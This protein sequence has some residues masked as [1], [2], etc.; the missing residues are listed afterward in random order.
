MKFW[1]SSAILPLCLKE[2]QTMVIK[3]ILQAEEGMVVWWATSVECCSAFAR[4]R[5]EKVITDLDEEKAR[6]I[7]TE[8]ITA[9]NEI[10]P[11]ENV[12]R[13]A[14]R[15]LLRHPLRAADSLQLAAAL[16]WT[17]EQTD[18][19]SFVCLDKRLQEAARREGFNIL[20]D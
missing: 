10:Q 8:L 4:L 15:I 19:H 13:S 2:P 3:K 6:K 9:W 16:A 20:P 12:R 11:C 1:D 17:Q 5:R 7:L 14:K 18:G